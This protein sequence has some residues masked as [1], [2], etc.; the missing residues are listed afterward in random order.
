MAK[1]ANLKGPAKKVVKKVIKKT[2]AKP[3]VVLKKKDPTADEFMQASQHPFKQE[4]ETLRNIIKQTNKKISERVKW[5]APSY[6]YIKDMAAFNLHQ[7]K[8][9]QLI[10][11]FPYGL[12][13]EN[14]LLEG[15]WKDR[16]EARFFDMKD[17]KSK[18]A[19]LEKTINEWVALTE[20]NN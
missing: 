18:K 17:I 13:P 9:V 12:I 19:V 3:K 4:I 1:K 7:Q 2:A 15:N 10:F 14:D 5:N 20:G 11:I 6:F 16:R 8:F